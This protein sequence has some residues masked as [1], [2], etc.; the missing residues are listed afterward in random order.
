MSLQSDLSPF[1]RVG[2]ISV[3]DVVMRTQEHA[4]QRA[5]KGIQAGVDSFLEELIVR[6]ELSVNMCWFGR[7]DYDVYEHTVPAFARASL[8]LHKADKR[9]VLY[10]YEELEAAVT[11]DSYW[12]AAQLE[13]VITGK[14]RFAS[15]RWRVRR[16]TPS[17]S[18]Q[19]AVTRIT[20]NI[21][22]A[23]RALF[24]Y[25]H[26]SNGSI[27]YIC[28]RRCMDI[29][30]S[31][32]CEFPHT[33]FGASLTHARGGGRRANALTFRVCR[34]SLCSLVSRV[35][36]EDVLGKANHRLGRRS[37]DCSRLLPAAE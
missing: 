22:H 20:S 26:P 10:S 3:V 24:N 7:D 12:N 32:P 28:S 19:D 6:R 33:T 37:G 9:P 1:L 18:I 13:L 8:E 14:V 5:N 35:S 17:T 4:K 11:G 15:S 2:A 25:G 36:Q 27:F 16:L 34:F 31:A 21:A 23:L 30:T 29:C